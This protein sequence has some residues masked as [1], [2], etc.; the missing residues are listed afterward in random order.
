MKVNVR[1]RFFNTSKM[2]WSRFAAIDAF[3]E[4]EVIEW[5]SSER[6]AS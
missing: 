3:V 4:G 6:L 1:I 5:Q 2:A